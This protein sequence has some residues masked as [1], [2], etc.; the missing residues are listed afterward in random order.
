MPLN[1]LVICWKLLA[2]KIILG[3]TCAGLGEIPELPNNVHTQAPP[4]NGHRHLYRTL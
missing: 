2:M 4:A 3:E 1:S